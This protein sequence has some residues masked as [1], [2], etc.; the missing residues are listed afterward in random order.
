MPWQGDRSNGSR[1]LRAS[2]NRLTWPDTPRAMRESI[3]E[4]GRMSCVE[5]R[6]NGPAAS[7]AGHAAGTT[8]G[9]WEITGGLAVLPP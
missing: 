8:G 4:Q 5:I 1:W 6:A 3:R 9:F 2:P 7:P